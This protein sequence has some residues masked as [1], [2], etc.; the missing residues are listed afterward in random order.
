VANEL[1][2]GVDTGGT[3]TD[4]LLDPGTGAP[5]LTYKLPSTPADPAQA[6]LDGVRTA[7]A[8][9]AEAQREEVTRA[10]QAGEPHAAEG[11][12]NDAAALSPSLNPF[13]V[14][15]STVAT[16]AL[17]E[18]K[19]ARAALIT[20]VGFV[21]TLWIGRQQ[22]PDLYALEPVKPAP[23]IARADVLEAQERMLCD[24]SVHTELTPAHCLALVE[25]V[26]ALGVESAAV[27]LLHSYANP[28]HEA[29]LA[30]AL[31]EALPGLPVTV[32]SELLPEFREY[33]RLAT[34]AVNAA[35]AP[36]MVRYTGRLAR[37]L[38]EGR[39]RIMAS[40]GGSLPPAVVAQRPVATILSGPAGGVVGAQYA[41]GLAGQVRI[42]T[43]DMGGT[44]TDVALCDGGIARTASGEIAGL[45]VRLPLIDIHTVGA[46]GG[47]LA[48]V[49]AG[50]ALAVGPESAGAD[51]G[52]ACYG[53]QRGELRPAVTD[54]HAVLGHLQP[55]QTLGAGLRL[56]CAAA[57]AALAPLAQAL[58]VT[59]PE[60][61]LGVLRVAEATMARAV[62]R[63]SMDRGHDPR[64]FTLLPFGGAGGL[65]AARLA[66][67]L[68]I[69]RV[70][71]PRHP[72]LL[73]ALGMLHAAPRYDFSQSVLARV[74][75]TSR[76]DTPASQGSEPSSQGDVPAASCANA[77]EYNLELE[78]IPAVA[79]VLDNL[80]I[81]GR[82]ALAVDGVAPDQQRLAFSADLRY[83]GQSFELAVPL[84]GR[85]TLSQFAARHRQLYGY[86]L[87]GAPVEVVTVR[88]EATG[89]AYALPNERLAPRG[90]P[91]PSSLGEQHEIYANGRWQ[92]CRFIQRDELRAGDSLPGP[93]IIT[94]YSATT[95]APEGWR[96]DV[97]EH[98]QLLLTAQAGAVR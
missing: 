26:R 71:I 40:A 34:C 47:S 5:L 91:L 79:S 31:R 16:N 69:T 65:H 2:I 59:L 51:P 50:C 14:H 57:T 80:R 84:A 13:V 81:Q 83:A 72:G 48:R 9:W 92:P 64:D 93:A 98:G 52:P 25:Q 18:G 36:P 8:R 94:E 39:L 87:P 60:A 37:E 97:N 3:F 61:A 6:V 66:D 15:G 1:R 28:A 30:V 43:L 19:C 32:S 35:V 55:G 88:L 24:G 49:D 42:I 63:I 73:S 44:S 90:A 27:C 29:A 53:R 82:A 77:A 22:R 10:K 41:A 68:G 12:L 89:P 85:E 86:N 67:Y 33:E 62:Q 17:L 45:P 11:A 46:G 74:E 76:E 96:L 56:D 4:V 38:G 20:T 23:P 58:G 7:L 95:L 78:C 54:A 75:T 21:D 70:L